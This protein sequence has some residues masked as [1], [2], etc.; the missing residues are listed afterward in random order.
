MRR[1]IP[2]LNMYSKHEASLCSLVWPKDRKR[3]QQLLSLHDD[4]SLTCTKTDG[5]KLH[6]ILHYITFQLLYGLNKQ[7]IMC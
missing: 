1:L 4:I 5:Y 2:L 3:R 7:D 6:F